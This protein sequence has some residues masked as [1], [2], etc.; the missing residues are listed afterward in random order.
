VRLAVLRSVAGGVVAVLF[1]ASLVSYVVQISEKGQGSPITDPIDLVAFYC[2]GRVLAERRDPYTI[3][4][5]R[6]CE[7]AALRESG[8]AIVP[9]LVVPAPLPPY[10]LAL[11]SAASLVPFRTASTVFFCASLFAIG[12]TIGLTIRLAR[13]PPLVIAGAFVVALVFGSLLIGQIVPIVLAALCASALALR[14]GRVWLSVAC[15]SLAMLEPHIGAAAL[16][17]IF[18]TERRARLPVCA[19]AVAL[20]ALSF[21][22]GGL[23]RNLEYALAVLPAHARSEVSNFYAQYS[24][25]A[26]LYACGV[27]AQAALRWGEC[28][29][30]AAFVCGVAVARKLARTYGDAAFAVLAPVAFALIGGAFIHIQQMAIALPLAFLFVRYGREKVLAFAAVALLAVPWESLYEIFFY[31]HVVPPGNP[32]AALAHVAD[33]GL[34]A[35]RVWQVWIELIRTRDARTPQELLLFKLPT[36]LGLAALALVAYWG[37]PPAA[38][39]STIR[40]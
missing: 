32:A 4:P 3:E 14:A 29:Y 38:V 15:A 36:W 40:R 2:G 35:D 31:T 13:G 28:S 22:A 30:V 1:A 10:A 24:L 23:D 27:P 25:T 9:N 18:V 37:S 6:T 26:L 19:S 20:A 21:A 16:A 33:P 17:G 5:L 12:V 11:F 34:L 7:R 8:I 39:R